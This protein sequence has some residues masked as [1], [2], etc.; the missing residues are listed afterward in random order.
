MEGLLFLS[1]REAGLPVMGSM[2]KLSTFKIE[3]FTV[4]I[5]RSDISIGQFFLLLMR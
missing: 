2:S 5:C 1:V 4:Q 3:L